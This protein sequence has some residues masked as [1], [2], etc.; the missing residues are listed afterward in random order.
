MCLKSVILTRSDMSNGVASAIY[1]GE[2]L[3]LN[4]GCYFSN[5]GYAFSELSLFHRLN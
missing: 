5:A 2:Q 1:I 3:K 4:R